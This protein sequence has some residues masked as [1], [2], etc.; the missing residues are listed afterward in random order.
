MLTMEEKKIK[1][2][3]GWAF[4]DNT[5]AFS[6]QN[7]QSCFLLMQSRIWLAFWAEGMLL[8]YV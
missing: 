8:A 7:H 6:S 2:D 3:V 4:L 5:P 1:E